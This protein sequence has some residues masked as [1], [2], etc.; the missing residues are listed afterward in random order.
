MRFRVLLT[1]VALLGVACG[2]D[3]S[4]S[5]AGSA[6]ASSAPS[7]G[8]GNGATFRGVTA[9]SI[10]VGITAVD[11]DALA[12]ANIR[13]GR[14]NS[15]DLYV[16][17]LEAVNDRGGIHGRTLEPVVE[18]FL[19][20]GST[21]FDR[22]C[23]S[24]TEDEDVFVAIGQAL[25][26]N[27][28]C[29]TELHDTA[30]VMLTGMTDELVAR[31][32]APYATVWSSLENRAAAFVAAMQDAGAL[33]GATI[34]VV[35]SADVSEIEYRT[36]VDAFEDAGHDVVEGLL[37]AN[38]DDILETQ[39]QQALVFER[40][41][42]AG[43]DLTVSTTGVPLEIANAIDAGYTSEHWALA[44][45][46]TAQGLTDAG[47]DQSYLDGALGVVNTPVGTP[48]QPMLADDPVASACV[49]D[50]VARTGHL[51]P[52]ALG[53]ET[54]DLV[55]ALYACSA[56]AILE[57]ALLAAGPDLTN[58]S[59]EAGLGS[60]GP[61]DL[62]GHFEGRLEPGDLGAAR[63]LMV[64]RFDASSGVWEPVG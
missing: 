26:S 8:G 55:E 7:P 2:G 33:D 60:I 48:A 29:F 47:V 10:K 14:S 53:A 4:T 41:T 52:Y 17:A 1:A 58:D 42:Q 51:L 6:P 32:N 43:V 31:S 18:Y 11:W 62:P 24:L 5:P 45:V 40:M 15:A 36:I 37:A 16:A 39:R 54:N 27:V 61:I 38:A 63:G 59:F 22:A 64:V 13:F 57:E 12:A 56:V 46:M 44:T 34:G 19:P 49:D 28:L 35:G 20:I 25:D 50:L 21:D 23:T 3:G 30:A 9:D